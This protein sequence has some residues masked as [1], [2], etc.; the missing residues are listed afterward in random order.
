[1]KKLA[2]M[3]GQVFEDD[4]EGRGRRVLRPIGVGQLPADDVEL[5]DVLAASVGEWVKGLETPVLVLP[6]SLPGALAGRGRVLVDADGRL[7]LLWATLG[8]EAKAFTGALEGRKWL[9]ENLGLVADACRQVNIDRSLDVGAIIV[10]GGDAGM[11]GQWCEA[12]SMAA[13]VRQLYLLSGDTGES[14]LVV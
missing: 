11:L 5:N 3:L 10:T 2:V 8:A 14:V 9:I 12:M 13:V 7:V 6:I 1:M 4:D